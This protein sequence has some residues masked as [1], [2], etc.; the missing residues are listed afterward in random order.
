MH[1]VFFSADRHTSRR[2]PPIPPREPIEEEDE[3][4]AIPPPPPACPPTTSTPVAM[5]DTTAD[6]DGSQAIDGV[7][8]AR[9][10]SLEKISLAAARS[11]SVAEGVVVADVAACRRCTRRLT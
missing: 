7:A 2:R 10:A 5:L 6:S 11:L 1:A 9:S 8:V 4:A 3:S